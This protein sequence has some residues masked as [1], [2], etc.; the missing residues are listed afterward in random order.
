MTDLLIVTFKRDFPYLR[1]CLK[2]IEKFVTGFRH[3]IILIP[4]QDVDDLVAVTSDFPQ[5]ESMIRIRIG[6]EWKNKGMLWHMHQIMCSDKLSEADYICHIDADCIFTA[7]VT[8]ETFIKDGKPILQYERFESINKRHPGVGIWGEVTQ[9]C[10]PFHVHFETMRQHG[11]TYTRETYAEAR[12]LIEV[13][14]GMTAEK[15]IYAQ[16][17]SFP[18]SFCEFVT[19]GNVAIHC[20]HDKYHLIDNSH[21]ENPDKGI[22]PIGQFWS[23]SG[24]DQPQDIWWEGKMER[25]VPMDMIKKVLG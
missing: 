13:K 9:R 18:Q 11:E 17:N 4:E 16:E 2:S 20:F 15:Y 8:P 10:L 12:R 5:L 3:V 6:Y 22:F 7:P 25:I 14:T 21:K 23:H 1:W 24:L 19:L